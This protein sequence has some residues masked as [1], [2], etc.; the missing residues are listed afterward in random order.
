MA[1]IVLDYGGVLVDHVDER[2]YAHLLGVDPDRDPYPGWLAYYLFRAGFL[3]TEGQYLELLSTLAGASETACVEYVE[4]T[5]LDPDFPE[6]RRAL[7]RE[8]ADDHSLVLFSNMAKPWVERVLARYGVGELFDSLL[9]SSELQRPKPHPK[10]YV[11]AM[12]D[13]DGATLM[14]SDEFDEDLLMAQCLGMT[15]VW[16]E[17][18]DED[19]YRRPAYTIDEFGELRS[20]LRRL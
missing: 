18:D 15:T 1:R 12:E 11:L 5:W 7:L 19:P 9:V 17:N 16:I 10:G 8:L 14:V 13:A 6:E 20:V 3:E 2:E 4:H